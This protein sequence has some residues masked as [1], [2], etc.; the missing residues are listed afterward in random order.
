MGANVLANGGIVNYWAVIDK[1]EMEFSC[2][3]LLKTV[4]F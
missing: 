3:L 2:N 1:K 4:Q